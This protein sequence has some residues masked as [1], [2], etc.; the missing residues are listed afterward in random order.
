MN[1]HAMAQQYQAAKAARTPE[2]LKAVRLGQLAT[3]RGRLF[4]QRHALVS[5]ARQRRRSASKLRKWSLTL[6]LEVHGEAAAR[7]AITLATRTADM[8]IGHE[9]GGVCSSS[10]R[11]VADPSGNS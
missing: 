2:Y 7:D 4:P 11:Q 10:C 3:V 1:M 8:G 9:G 5:S 6:G